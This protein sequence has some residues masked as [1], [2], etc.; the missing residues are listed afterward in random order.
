MGVV[1]FV[2]TDE[3]KEDE[4]EDDKEEEDEKEDEIKGDSEDVIEGFS[5]AGRGWGSWY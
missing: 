3:D 1:P 5:G 4:G 2:G